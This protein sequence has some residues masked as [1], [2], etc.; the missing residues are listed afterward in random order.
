LPKGTILEA[1]VETL[2]NEFGAAL[3]S[4]LTAEEMADVV[5]RNA[6]EASPRICHSHDFCDANELLLE[7]FHSH[8]MD[9]ADEGGLDR[10]GKLWD[11]AWNLAKERG[12]PAD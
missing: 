6:R 1:T 2:A 12:F 5:E 7:V 9:V 8:G 3:R 11:D 4:L 10:W